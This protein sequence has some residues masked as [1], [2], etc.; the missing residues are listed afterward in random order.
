[1]Q[2]GENLS[3]RLNDFVVKRAHKKKIDRMWKQREK[4]TISSM[5]CIDN[6]YTVDI[7]R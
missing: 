5:Y 7:A 4:D 2:Y 1:M 3:N 6:N